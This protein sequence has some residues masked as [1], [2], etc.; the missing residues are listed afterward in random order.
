MQRKEIDVGLGTSPL[1]FEDTKTMTERMVNLEEYTELEIPSGK[2][3][4]IS[5]TIQEVEKEIYTKLLSDFE[6]VFAK[7]HKDL[8]GIPVEIAEH[9][10]DLIE[11]AIPV[12]QKQYRLNPQHSM[13]VKKELDKLIDAG[14]IY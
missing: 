10:I 4:N 5:V 13:L 2:K 12:R 8:K 7:S 3:F 6:D 1:Y 9:R 11:G 14:F